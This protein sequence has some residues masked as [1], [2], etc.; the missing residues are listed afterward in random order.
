MLVVPGDL[1]VPRRNRDTE[2]RATEL[3]NRKRGGPQ[4]GAPGLVSS[5]HP[6]PHR[7]ERATRC[8]HLPAV[9]DNAAKTACMVS[10]RQ[11]VARDSQ[12]HV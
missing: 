1:R 7:R 3:R 9:W 8:R 11:P 2:M 6:L 12:L 10:I 5:F 4:A